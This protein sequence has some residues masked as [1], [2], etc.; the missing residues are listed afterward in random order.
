MEVVLCIFTQLDCIGICYFGQY[1]ETGQLKVPGEA[2]LSSL[3]RNLYCL[4]RIYKIKTIKKEIML[5]LSKNN[6]APLCLFCTL[7][8]THPSK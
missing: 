3:Y 8:P 1:S 4:D 6:F 5:I 2:G 7:L